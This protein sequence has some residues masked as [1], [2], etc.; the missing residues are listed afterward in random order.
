MHTCKSLKGK[1]TKTKTQSSFQR[2]QNLLLRRQKPQRKVRINFC[3]R[4]VTQ[5]GPKSRFK[6]KF[7]HSSR[8]TF[9][10]SKHILLTLVYFQL[11]AHL[12]TR[13]ALIC[14]NRYKQCRQCTFVEFDLQ[15]LRRDSFKFTQGKYLESKT[16]EVVYSI[17]MFALRSY[18]LKVFFFLQ[19]PRS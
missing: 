16:N 4:F 8:F 14:I 15:N 11:V 2:K 5:E 1:L 17:K 19:L 12:V 7:H 10:V 18:V 3:P 13:H 6:H 9:T